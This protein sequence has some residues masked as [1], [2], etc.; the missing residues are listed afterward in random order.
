MVRNLF[1]L[2]IVMNCNIK[3][4]KERRSCEEAEIAL[5]IGRRVISKLRVRTAVYTAVKRPIV[6]K[7]LV[8]F[9]FFQR[10]CLKNK[11]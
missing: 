2:Q 8:F 9:F 6:T 5:F 4:K 11:F 3:K 1:G 7:E 10:G